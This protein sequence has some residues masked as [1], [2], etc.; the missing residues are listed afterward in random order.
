MKIERII[1]SH[2]IIV[3]FN[4]IDKIIMTLFN[5]PSLGLYYTQQHIQN[6]FP[7]L[8]NNM[9]RLYENRKTINNTIQDLD[10]TEKEIK[11]ISSLNEDFS[12][13]ML[14]R[15]NYLNFELQRK[16]T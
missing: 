8:L 2:L 14:A 5:E 1:V 7:S 16:K 15:I 9:D 12:F 10:R 6:S 11:E 4:N 13:K 3:V